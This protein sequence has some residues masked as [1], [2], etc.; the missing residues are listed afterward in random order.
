MAM[1][2]CHGEAGSYPDSEFYRPKN[3][4]LI[5]KR[6]LLHYVNG[7]PVDYVPD[8]SL[9]IRIQK[10]IGQSRVDA[11]VMSNDDIQELLDNI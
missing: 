11:S 9:P 10:L 4:Q 7:D 5:H 6:G 3:G 1:I 2:Y 8:P